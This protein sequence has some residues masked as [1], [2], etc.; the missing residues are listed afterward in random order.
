MAGELIEPAGRRREIIEAMKTVFGPDAR[1]IEHALK[2]LDFAE[3]LL[4]REPGCR[5]V[6]VAAAIL[7]DIGI[8]Q[9]ELK[10]GSA[11]G[12]YQEIEGPPIAREILEKLEFE[13]AVIDHVCRIIANHHSAR[14]IDTPEFRILWDADW[15]VNIPDEHPHAARPELERLIGRVFRTAAGRDMARS[16]Y[17]GDVGSRERPE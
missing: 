10:H 14:D 17:L 2:V 13:E 8:R 1:R 7:H 3:A 15:L 5:E 12:G 16:R 11:A 6:V 4:A 9:A